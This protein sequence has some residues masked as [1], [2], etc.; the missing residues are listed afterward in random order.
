M[1]TKL[2]NIHL[3]FLPD[4]VGFTYFG[5]LM[6]DAEIMRMAFKEKKDYM[7]ANANAPEL[8][9]SESDPIVYLV[10]SCKRDVPKAA[11]RLA[12]YWKL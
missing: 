12:L 6:L 9:E 8:I 7:D 1:V 11:M 2:A 10:A 5:P 4:Y 3:G